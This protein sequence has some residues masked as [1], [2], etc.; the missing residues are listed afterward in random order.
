MP[1]IEMRS[2]YVVR[3]GLKLL[4]SSNPPASASEIET[5]FH[6]VGQA[7]FG[8]LTASDPPASASQS[9]GITGP[10]SG[11]FLWDIY[12]KKEEE[13]E[14]K[15]YQQIFYS[16][17]SMSS[18]IVPAQNL[19]ILAFND[20]NNGPI[21]SNIG[22]MQW[23]TPGL[24]VS[25][26]PESSGTIFAHCNIYL[27]GSSNSHASATQV[28]G[29]TGSSLSPRLECSG[30]ITTHCSLDLQGSSNPPASAFQVAKPIETVLTMLPRMISNL[31]SSDPPT[32]AFQIVGII[33]W[34]TV[35][36]S[37]LTATSASW[38]QEFKT[39]L[40]N[41]VKPH[42]Y[43]KYKNYLGMVAHA[44]SPSYSGG[45]GKRIAG[46]QEEE[47]ALFRRLRWEDH[48]NLEGRGCLL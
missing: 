34:S 11:F 42:L 28:A 16:S 19:I 23:L 26:R 44:C 13:E 2:Q 45:Q 27:P 24:A 5:G 18:A 21:G 17:F 43:Q 36:Q 25:P 47:A 31:T 46:T 20:H 12:H 39:S 10:I 41:M 38:V 48:L 14:K 29:I 4:G 1:D 40:A 3:T 30:A 7:V 35:V 33:G 9:A 37:P 6:H 8:L 22:Q 15:L 32:P